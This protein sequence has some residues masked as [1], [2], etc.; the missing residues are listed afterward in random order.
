MK[1][2]VDTYVWIELFTGSKKGE[3][4]KEKLTLAEEVYTS[5]IFLAEP[6]ENIID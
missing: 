6:L 3:I 4:V 5:D 2:V 1:I